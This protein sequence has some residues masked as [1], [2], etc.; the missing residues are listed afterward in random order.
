MEAGNVFTTQL[1]H[2]PILKESEFFWDTA[3]SVAE[4]TPSLQGEVAI[5]YVSQDDRQQSPFRYRCRWILQISVVRD[6]NLRSSI[7]LQVSGEVCPGDDARDGGEEHAEGDEEVWVVLQLA[8]NP[9]GVQ[10][11]LGRL[12]TPASKAIGMP[13]GRQFKWSQRWYV[14]WFIPGL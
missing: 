13:L 10:V 2:S 12:H 9:V 7:H 5:G 1:C 4:H 6:K 11:V 3:G 14:C 8:V